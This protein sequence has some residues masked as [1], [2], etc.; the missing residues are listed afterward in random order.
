[1]EIPNTSDSP[2]QVAV[3]AQMLNM[4]QAQGAGLVSMIAS[5]PVL[6]GS[7]NQPGQGLHIDFHA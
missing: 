3:Q 6:R 5:T 7:V 4:M 1:M 2:V